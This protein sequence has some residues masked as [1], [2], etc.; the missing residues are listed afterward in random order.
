MFLSIINMKLILSMVRFKGCF[1]CGCTRI[2]CWKNI[3]SPLNFLWCLWSFVLLTSG[4]YLGST[5]KWF[6]KVFLKRISWGKMI[7]YSPGILQTSIPKW[8]TEASSLV[9]WAASGFSLSSVHLFL[10]YPAHIKQ[11]HLK[12]FLCNIHSH[13]WFYSSREPD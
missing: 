3:L 4:L 11:T 5:K 1:S 6:M 12:G 10:Y 13:Y 7:R 2:I 9:D 8:T